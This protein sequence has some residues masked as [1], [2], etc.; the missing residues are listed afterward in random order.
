MSELTAL[1][2]RPVINAT[3]PWTKMGNSAPSPQI[4]QVMDEMAASF[5]PMTEL[6]SRAS[7]VISQVTGSEAGYVTAGAASAITLAVAACVAGEDPNRIWSIPHLVEP[8]DT[9]VLFDAHRW[10]YDFAVRA[11]GVKLE[12]VEMRAPDALQRLER[13]LDPRVVACVFYDCTGLPYKDPDGTPALEDVVAVAHRKGVRVVADASMA[14]PPASNLRAIV[15]TGAD[16]VAFSGGKALQGPAASGFVACRRN[17]V[18]SIAVQQMDTNVWSELT[19]EVAPDKLFMGIGRSAKVGK[20]QIAGLV[21]ALLAY[22]Q[23]DHEAVSS[24]WRQ[25]LEVIEAALRDMAGVTC[26]WQISNEGRAPY[27]MIGFENSLAGITT[28]SVSQRLLEGA[29]R[30]FLAAHRGNVLWAGAE[31]LQD[32]EAEIVGD[33]LAAVIRDLSNTR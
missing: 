17:L 29:P 16:A 6:Q 28:A 9:V 25:R 5:V 31:C 1:G 26:R 2:I 27:L 3:G 20:E 10:F 33:R 19:G 15:G 23:A 7:E 21:A 30:I 8:P 24:R 13:A 32:G 14:L 4:R 22:S 18:R 11:T 12:T